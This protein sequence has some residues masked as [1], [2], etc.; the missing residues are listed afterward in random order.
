M[1][2]KKGQYQVD[3]DAE[4]ELRQLLVDANTHSISFGNARGVRNL[5]EK[6]LVC[7]AN[8]LAAQQEEVTTEELMR[9]TAQDILGVNER[10][11]EETSEDAPELSEEGNA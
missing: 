4:D 8:R 3:A 6:V 1:Q 10:E 5:F 9:I 7:Q 11:E 2:C